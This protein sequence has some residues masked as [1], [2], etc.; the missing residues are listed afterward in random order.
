M[1][2]F[3]FIILTRNEWKEH[4]KNSKHQLDLDPL[5]RYRRSHMN[6]TRVKKLIEQLPHQSFRIVDEKVAYTEQNIPRRLFGVFRGLLIVNE[7]N[8]VE[9]LK[10]NERIR[11]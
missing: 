10:V 9:N 1:I 7:T 5:P 6:E 11:N 8:L 3:L 4:E 2:A